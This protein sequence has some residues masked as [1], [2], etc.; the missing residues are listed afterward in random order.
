VPQVRRS[1]ETRGQRQWC[2]QEEEER[3]EEADQVKD[4]QQEEEEE[5]MATG[6]GGGR[7]TE[8]GRKQEDKVNSCSSKRR[9]INTRPR[10]V[11]GGGSRWSKWGPNPV[12]VQLLLEVLPSGGNRRAPVG[13]PLY[14]K[15]SDSARDSDQCR[16]QPPGGSHNPTAQLLDAAHEGGRGS[17]RRVPHR[18]IPGPL[19]I[20]L[21]KQQV[22]H[23]LLALGGRPCR[24]KRPLFGYPLSSHGLGSLV[25]FFLL[26]PSWL[27]LRLRGG[28]S[29]AA[30]MHGSRSRKA[31]RGEAPRYPCLGEIPATVMSGY[32]V[33]GRGTGGSCRPED[34]IQSRTDDWRRKACQEP[35]A[36]GELG[37]NGTGVQ[38]GP[39][40]RTQR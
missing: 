40:P 10:K 3:E 24:L 12:M 13:W 29:L 17:G 19:C 7:S 6:G 14:C 22:L 25:L 39:V 28:N 15:P 36:A 38:R 37:S 5:A 30:A 11:E 31:A 2:E 21:R 32:G 1:H 23:L 16:Q 26:L 33:K 34:G 9:T 18:L 35:R 20:E 27:K 8:E 4:Q